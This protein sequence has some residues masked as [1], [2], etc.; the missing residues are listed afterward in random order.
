MQR[1]IRHET[2]SGEQRLD[3]FFK[4]NGVILFAF[5]GGLLVGQVVS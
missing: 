4:E 3:T 1:K 5:S 2:M